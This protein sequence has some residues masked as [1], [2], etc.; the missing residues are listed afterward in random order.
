[1]GLGLLGRGLGDARFLAEQGANVLVTDLKSEDE[2]K[3]SVEQLKDFSNVSFVLGRHREIDFTDTDMVIKAAGVP[4]DSPYIEVARKSGVLVYMS[5]ALFASLTPSTVVGVTG[6]RGK[7]TVTHLISHILEKSG[8]QVFLGGNVRGVSTLGHLSSVTSEEIS[9]LELDSWQLQGFAD[10]HLSPSYA[11]FTTFFPDH[12]NYYK[13]DID[14]YLDD[15]ANIFRYQKNGDV[16]VVGDQAYEKLK[17]KYR[18]YLNE[19]T[20]VTRAEDLPNDWTLKILGKHNRYNATIAVRL[21]ESLGVSREDI[22]SALETFTGVSGRL[23]YCGK[24]SNRE[25][26][27]DNSST[28]PEATVVALDALKE[29]GNIFLILGGQDKNLKTDKLV[30]S[31]EDYVQKVY[32]LPG[33][34][35]DNLMSHLKSSKINRISDISEALKRSFFESS[36][37]DTVLFSPGFSSF[38][39]FD[40]EYHR[41]K[42]FLENLD[43]YKDTNI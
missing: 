39:Q 18:E 2:L 37:G 13:G 5:T 27:N 10:I 21:A 29:K 36:E 8:R 11:G 31:I 9:V 16:L 6:T 35:S 30:K 7:S 26:Y 32:L 17:D 19:E 15:K 25:V 23:E 41:E 38:F 22:K 3:E 1:M 43:S 12:L 14:R 42:I 28:T 40:N 20:F 4:L 24:Y 34:G 33:S